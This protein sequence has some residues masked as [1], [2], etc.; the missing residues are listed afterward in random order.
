[1]KLD[2]YFYEIK[3]VYIFLLSWN[4]RFIR[5]QRDITICV[6]VWLLIISNVLVKTMSGLE[7]TL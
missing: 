4:I 1:M 7:K 3:I 5:R 6:E 2:I